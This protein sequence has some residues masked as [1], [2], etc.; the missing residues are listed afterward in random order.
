MIPA[1]YSDKSIVLDILCASFDTN[2]SIN[3]VIKQGKNR[4][5]EVRNLM[6][7]SF[8]ICYLFGKVW[9]SNDKKACALVLFPDKKKTSP[10]TI[11]LDLR[12]AL[13]CIGITRVFKILKRDSAIK[14]CYPKPP[15]YYLWFIGV[16]VKEQGKGIGKALLNEIITESVLLKRPIYLET[17]MAENIDFYKK[18]G[19][20]LYHELDFGYR[21]F[22]LKRSF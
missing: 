11:F 17:S 22:L 20:E 21:L 7:Y 16:K 1:H 9:L 14:S 10:K 12:L 18:A 13:S 3:Y 4:E 2:K 6:G 8:E 5:K 19:F 15:I